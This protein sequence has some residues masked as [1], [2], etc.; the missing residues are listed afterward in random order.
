MNALL[1][2]YNDYLR[3]VGCM[4]E[5]ELVN[6]TILTVEYKKENFPHLLGLHKLKDIQLIQFW[7][8][9][10]NKSVK[11][12]DVIKNI[13]KEKLT[14]SKI[15]ASVFYP[16]IKERYENFSYDNLTTLTYTDAIINFNASLMKSK[17]KSDYLLFEERPVSG[18]YN[19]L[20]IARDAVAS[21]RYFE[22]FFHE[23]TNKYLLGQT[24]VPIKAFRILDAQGNIFVED[25]F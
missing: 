9:R 3:L 7:N 17:I 11:L 6:G 20:G 8:D 22:T 24:I 18:E 21:T 13:E 23:Y 4:A 10:S 15:K 19:H 25:S 12:K 5:Y 16:D 14:D 2:K 1:E